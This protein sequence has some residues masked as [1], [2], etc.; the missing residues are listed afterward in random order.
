MSCM[1]D[2]CAATATGSGSDRVITVVVEGECPH[3]GYRVALELTNEGFWDDPE[4]VALDLVID[5][6]EVG[7]DTMTPFKVD[8]EV[9]GDPATRVRLGTPDGVKGIEIKEG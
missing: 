1:I 9:R 4:V 6:E 3:T 2:R 8:R 7:E 5:E